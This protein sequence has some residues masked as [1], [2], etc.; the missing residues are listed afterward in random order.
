VFGYT[1][2]IRER[3]GRVELTPIWT[4]WP[5]G[6]L[7]HHEAGRE[8]VGPES[9]VIMDASPYYSTLGR[10]NESEFGATWTATACSTAGRLLRQL[11]CRAATPSS[12]STWSGRTTPPAAPSRPGRG[13]LSAVV[14]IDWLNGRA[15]GYDKDGNEVV[16][17]WRNSRTGMIGKSTGRLQQRGLDRRRRPVGDRS[18]R[19]SRPGTTTRA[20]T[21]S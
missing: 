14:G 12:C 19:R 17:D 2:A 10:G 9:A 7:R 21:A 1:D 11:L 4:A 15:K 13:Y 16:A 3:V 8:R 18:D 5:T 6:S 20:P